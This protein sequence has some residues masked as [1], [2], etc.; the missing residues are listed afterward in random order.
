M[1]GEAGLSAILFPQCPG[2]PHIGD[3]SIIQSLTAGAHFYTC[4]Q[5]CG[6][7]IDVRRDASGESSEQVQPHEPCGTPFHEDSDSHRT[8]IHVD[9]ILVVALTLSPK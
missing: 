2:G 8:R 5:G 6:R 7:K 9:G 4:P 3:L 1:T